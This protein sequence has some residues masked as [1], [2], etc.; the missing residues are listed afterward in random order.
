M[1]DQELLELASK[2]AGIE[3]EAL[4]EYS[5]SEG[6]WLKGER[7]PDNNRFWNPLTDD[8]DA[9]RLSSSLHLQI[10]YFGGEVAVSQW[11]HHGVGLIHVEK[12]SDN[13]GDELKSLRRAIVRAAAEAEMVD[14]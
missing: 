6:L 10:E 1:T 5:D 13:G 7:S 12:Y 4:A 11:L 8:G 9:F 2:V 3:A 14:P